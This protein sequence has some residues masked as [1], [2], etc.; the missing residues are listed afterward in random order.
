MFL[1]FIGVGKIEL[2]KVLVEVFFDDELVFICFD[3]SE[4]MEK[5]A[6]SC[7]NGVFLGYVGYEE[8][9][10]LIE[11]VCNKLY[12]VFFFDEVEKVYLDIFNV[13]LQ[14]LDDGVLIDSKG[15]KV[16]FLNI[17]IIMTLNF[18]VIVFWD[19]KIVGFGVKDICFDQ[20]NMEK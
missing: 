15:C 2:V 10:E 6:V 4:Y 18:G 9:G 1:G 11:K 19:D 12:F 13:F 14:V 7:F 17:I 5:F 8:G 20:E 3:M 16:D